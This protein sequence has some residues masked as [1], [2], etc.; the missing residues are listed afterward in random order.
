MPKRDLVIAEFCIRVYFSGKVDWD[1]AEQLIGRR[2]LQVPRD[3]EGER[4]AILAIRSRRPRRKKSVWRK[5]S[6]T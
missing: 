2:L 5:S 1:G 4:R 6:R 3:L